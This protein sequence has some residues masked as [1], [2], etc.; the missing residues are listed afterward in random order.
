M[1][2]QV[3]RQYI[4]VTLLQIS[5]IV[6][7]TLLPLQKLQDDQPA[8]RLILRHIPMEVIEHL[9]YHVLGLLQHP[10]LQAHL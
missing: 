9:Q 1:E 3:H 6:V 5:A 8:Q 2:D 4:L 10:D 7:G